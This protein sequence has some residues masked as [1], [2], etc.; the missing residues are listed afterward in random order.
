MK[1]KVKRTKKEKHLKAVKQTKSIWTK[2][3]IMPEKNEDKKWT[4]S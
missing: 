4:I 1:K 3:P 2:T